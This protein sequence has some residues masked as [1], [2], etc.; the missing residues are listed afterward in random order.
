MEKRTS[1]ESSSGLLKH[2]GTVTFF[3]LL[4]RILG[5][6][7]DL[8]IAH[9][10]GAGWITDAFVQAFTIPNVLRRLTAE[11]A[12]NQAFL[13]LYTEIREKENTAAAGVFASKSMGMVL[14]GTLLL[15]LLGML[16]APQ[17]VTLFAAGFLNNPEQFELCVGLTQLMFPYL[18]LVSLVAWATGILNAESHFAAPAAAPI[19]LNLGIIGAAFSISPL[20]DQPIYGIAIGV[21]IGG[22]LQVLL[23]LPSLKKTGHSLRPVFI[24]ND[25]KIR[26]L[27]KLLGPTLLGAGVYQIN[28]VVLRNLA[29]FLPQGQ[30]TH[31]Y[32]ASRLSELV[33]GVFAFGIVSASL[34]ELSLSIARKNWGQLGDTLRIGTASSLLLVIPASAGLIAL[35]EPIVSML[36]FHGAYAWNDVRLTASALQAFALSLPAVA[37]M[38]MLTSVYFSFQDTKTPV[39]MAFIGIPVT[40][41]LGWYWSSQL[42]VQGLALG[43]SAGTFFQLLLLSWNFRKF[44]NLQQ[45]WWP[46]RSMIVIIAASAMMACAAWWCAGFGNWE[47]GPFLF[48]NWLVLAGAIFAGAFLYLLLMLILKE[49][50]SLRLLRWLKNR[51][52]SA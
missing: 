2:A 52:D 17:L 23:Q 29:S 25:P 30:V 14:A 7:R 21:L 16:F 15:T 36:F 24:L 32:N 40:G 33:L 50:Q 35:A 3:T 26:K 43:L 13:P 5:A 34:P 49:E 47:E 38:R 11:G 46:F 18:M 1:E 27:L 44:E 45:N 51:R 41:V 31:Y 12:M 19:L 20:L 9:F 39:K 4:S 28:I 22:G 42:E 10:F 8:V 37:L 48:W 6:A